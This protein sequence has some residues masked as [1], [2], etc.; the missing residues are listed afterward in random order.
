MIRGHFNKSIH[1]IVTTDIKYLEPYRHKE[2]QISRLRLGMA[3]TNQRLFVMKRHS[4]GLCDTCQIKETIDHL[5]LDC[6]KEDISELLRN[7]CLLYKH[8]ISIN[9]LEVR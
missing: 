7:K 1:S 3:N 5:L 9:P 8:E 4:N 2:V 6:V